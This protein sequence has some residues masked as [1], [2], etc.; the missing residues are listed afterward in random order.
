MNYQEVRGFVY[1]P[2]CIG[3]IE[4]NPCVF[5]AALASKW[6]VIHST[7]TLRIIIGSTVL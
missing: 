4:Q 6:T 5:D 2:L 3:F 7:K 1:N